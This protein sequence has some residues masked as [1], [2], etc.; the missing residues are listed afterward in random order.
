MAVQFSTRG[1]SLVKMH[2][3]NAA[4]KGRTILGERM[5]KFGELIM[6]DS[7]ENYVPVDQGALRDTGTVREVSHGIGMNVEIRLSY[8]G[9]GTTGRAIAIHERPD[10][11]PP[12]WEGKSDLNWTKPGTG[13]KY[14]ELP[15]M[16]HSAKVPAV[17]AEA[18]VMAL[19]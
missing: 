2:L 5:L 1:I 14:L 15:V 7:K 17:V 6:N 10:N 9:G 3:T 4:I 12:T 8:G 13:P 16:H 11:D 19:K 18:L